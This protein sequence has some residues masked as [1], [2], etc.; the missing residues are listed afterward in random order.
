MK[1]LL[2]KIRLKYSLIIVL[3]H[4]FI[5]CSTLSTLREC[6]SIAIMKS[7]P[8]PFLLLVTK[9]M[10]FLT[11]CRLNISFAQVLLS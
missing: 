10:I 3:L 2:M 7:H 11:C 8:T 9:G 1:H 5:S 6:L 4:V